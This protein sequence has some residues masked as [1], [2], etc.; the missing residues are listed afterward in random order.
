[1]NEKFQVRLDPQLLIKVNK[2]RK[3][4]GL[5]W[6]YVVEILFSEYLRNGLPIVHL[7]ARNNEK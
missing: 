5:P 7:T 6:R 1:M 3:K 2:K 4:N